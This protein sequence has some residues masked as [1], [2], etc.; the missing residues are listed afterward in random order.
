MEER[1]LL[2]CGCGCIPIL[3]I[4]GILLTLAV[5]GL[6]LGSVQHFSGCIRLGNWSEDTG[7]VSSA[8][9]IDLKRVLKNFICK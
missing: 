6:D 5:C 2:G 3:V 7:S 9:L 4:L 1:G 8:N